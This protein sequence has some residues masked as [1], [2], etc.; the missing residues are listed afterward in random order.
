MN[1]LF[2][3]LFLVSLLGIPI[4]LIL[5]I[6]NFLR[7]KRVKPYLASCGISLVIMAVSFIGFGFTT[8]DVESSNSTHTVA[9]T[10]MEKS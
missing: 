1:N 6:V 8:N 4:C 3:F 7:R 9:S 2:L 10:E 5:A